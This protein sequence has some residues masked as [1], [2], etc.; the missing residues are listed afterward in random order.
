[1]M[2]SVQ[3]NPTNEN[4]TPYIMILH[5]CAVAKC[6]YGSPS[7]HLIIHASGEWTHQL[8]KIATV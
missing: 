5:V 3:A 4:R 7:N 6:Y 1:M 8:I 2:A